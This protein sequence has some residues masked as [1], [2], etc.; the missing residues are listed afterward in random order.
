MRGKLGNRT[1]IFVIEYFGN[2]YLVEIVRVH[3]EKKNIGDRCNWQFR[4]LR[5]HRSGFEI[6]AYEGPFSFQF[7]KKIL[8][9]IVL[10]KISGADTA[11]KTF[12]VG[13]K[14]AFPTGNFNFNVIWYASCIVHNS[15]HVHIDRRFRDGKDQVQPW[16]IIEWE[17]KVCCKHQK[18]CLERLRAAPEHFL[19]LDK[20]IK[21]QFWRKESSW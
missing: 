14:T 17:E 4:V 21:N 8:K 12:H 18:R 16:K 6:I 15:Y 3:Y 1:C 10:D 9:I 2:I 11:N 19:G 5:N 7:D 13:I 20:A